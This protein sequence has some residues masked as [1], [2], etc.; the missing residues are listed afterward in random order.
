MLLKFSKS[1]DEQDTD[2]TNR[3]KIRSST[4]VMQQ[5][6]VAHPVE[7]RSCEEGQKY[8]LDHDMLKIE[9]STRSR[10]GRQSGWDEFRTLWPKKGPDL[11]QRQADDARGSQAC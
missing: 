4:K 10:S 1:L 8:T 2:F 3:T 9:E 11:G 6:L 7:A 5:N